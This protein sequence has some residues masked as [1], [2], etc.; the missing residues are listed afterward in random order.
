MFEGKQGKFKIVIELA[1]KRNLEERKNLGE[2]GYSFKVSN[3]SDNIENVFE[4]SKEERELFEFMEALDLEEIKIL[5]TVMY[6][7]R[8]GDYDKNKTQDEVYND[9]R[10]YM[11][12]LG[13]NEKRIEID[14]M[15]SKFPLDNYLEKGFNI[16][17]VNY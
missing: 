16:L 8:D 10:E 13:W 15:V 14:H 9:Y 17:G 11:D 2:E 12:T 6:L 1:K 7:G 5:R 4:M 3:L